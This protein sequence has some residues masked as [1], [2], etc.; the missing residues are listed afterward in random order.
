MWCGSAAILAGSAAVLVERRRNQAIRALY[1]AVVQQERSAGSRLAEQEAGIVRLVR[2]VLP[3]LIERLRLGCSPEEALAEAG[4][5]PGTDSGPGSGSPHGSAHVDLLRS[6]LAAVRAEEE[7]RQSAQRAF[8]NIARRV[9]AIVHQQ[10]G[11]LREMEERHGGLPDVFGDLLQVDHG[12]ALIG[13]LADSIAVLGGER[14]GRHWTEPI[15]VLSVLRG[16]MSR[17]IDYRR[18]DIG[19]ITDAALA[20]PVVEPVIHALAELLDNA[21]RYS[22]P[23]SRVHL[24]AHRVQ[25]GFVIVVEDAGVGLGPE[26]AARAE[27]IL[28]AGSVGL[29]LLEL[30][31]STRLGLSVASRL[32]HANDFDVTLRRSAYGGVRAVVF[33]PARLITEVPAPVASATGSGSASASAESEAARAEAERE[34]A[35]VAV[36]LPRR[37]RSRVPVVAGASEDSPHRDRSDRPGQTGPPGPSATGDQPQPGLWLSTF[38]PRKDSEQ[39]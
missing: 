3:A 24:T 19:D 10:L 8:V 26:A 27:R 38:M 30:G 35:A 32:A 7:M 23:E 33:L 20:G 6:V 25:A 2:E 12:T 34:A 16:A 5:A 28:T 22:P 21:T 36:A 18:V 31:T 4:L 13:R 9:Q 11:D 14:P 15:A 1:T 29:N 37:R 17:I 39:A